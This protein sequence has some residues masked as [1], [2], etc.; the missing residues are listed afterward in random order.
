MI[1]RTSTVPL[2]TIKKKHLD[3]FRQALPSLHAILKL[4]FAQMDIFV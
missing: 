4:I 1:K 3:I 2:R